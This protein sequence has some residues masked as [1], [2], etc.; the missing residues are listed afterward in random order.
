MSRDLTPQEA[1]D[2]FISRRRQRQAEETVR[3]YG[4]RLDRFVEWCEENGIE[5]IRE[6]GGW[7]IDEFRH[8][9]ESA[10]VAPSTVKGAMVALKQL[11]EFCERIE[12]V[13]EGV[14]DKVEI[15]KLS[16]D[17]ETSD[18]QLHAD[19]AREILDYLR[20]S[21]RFFGHPWHA[22]LE[23]T[24][25]TGCRVGGLRSLDLGDYDADVG[26]LRFHHRPDLGTPLKNKEAGER[27]VSINDDVV[28]ALDSYIARERYDKNDEYGREPLFSARQGRPT[29]TTLR[30]YSYQVTQPCLHTGCPH[31]RER[32]SCEWTSRNQASKCPSSRSPHAIRTGAITWLLNVT[33]GDIE[34]VANRVN[35][36]PATIRR[37]YDKASIE[38]EFA[39]R[40]QKYTDV[41]INNESA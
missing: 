32:H 41:D 16:K 9:R 28:A 20:N 17:E 22:F 37:Y 10:G 18:E 36:K 15:P 40:Q 11:L 1:R 5:T 7:E 33:D 25:H 12:V 26:T 24:W 30:A 2:R 34:W 29:R 14:S 23:V 3:S 13:D 8:A 39:H 21:K 38:E 31:S 35:A 4:H 19:R 27:I 6:V